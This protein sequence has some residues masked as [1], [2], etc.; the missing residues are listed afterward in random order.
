[1]VFAITQTPP[2]SARAVA[3]SKTALANESRDHFVAAAAL[4]VELAG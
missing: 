2:C 3:L 4:A 1:V